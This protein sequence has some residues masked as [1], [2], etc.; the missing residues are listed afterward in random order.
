L[1][2]SHPIEVPVK[3][4]D[5]ISQIF[6]AI[7]YSKGSCV[8]RMISKYLGE[9]V[10]MEG[11]RRY[12]KK[13]AFGNTQTGDLWAALS[14][15]S[16]KDVEQVMDI[17]TKKVGYPVISVKENPSKSSITV[18]QNRYLRTNDV[19]P[20]EDETLFPVFLGLRSKD[21]I[22]EDITLTKREAEIPVKDLDF[23]K[24]NADHAGIYRTSYSP[25]R[26]E[27]L[28]QAAKDNLLS[29]E[30]RAGLISD[31]GA[32]AASGHSKTSGVLSLLKGLKS[33]SEFIVWNEILVRIAAI[34]GAW[35]F[36][37]DKV[38]KAIKEFRLGL[39]QDKAHEIGWDFSDSDGH[40]MQQFKPMLFSN[41]GQLG[42]ETI[43]KFAFEQF[44]KFKAGDRNAIH[45]NLRTSIYA[46][47]L[48]H[49]G[50]EEVSVTYHLLKQ[51]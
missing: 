14:D 1:R 18:T 45:P 2:S 17:W 41:A 9:D 13:H 15:A 44:N 20:E 10:F 28:G 26:L 42:D 37:D 38:Q 30:D 11:I 29:T 36:E 19:K 23:Y 8:L 33:E 7:S 35:V 5:E 40:I 27:K 32:L 50:V 25:E 43:V 51:C 3:R 39:V 4:A 31:A 21:G 46:I 22:D 6:D 49:G 24:V 34:R 48:T 47:V 16:G 12:L